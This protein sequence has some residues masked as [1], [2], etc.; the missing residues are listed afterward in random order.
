VEA[1]FK[2]KEALCLQI[3]KSQ[4]KVERYTESIEGYGIK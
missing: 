3:P 2:E 1:H 4:I